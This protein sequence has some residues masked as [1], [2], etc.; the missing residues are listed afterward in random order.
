MSARFAAQALGLSIGLLVYLP[1][2]LDAANLSKVATRGKIILQEKM[3]IVPR[4]RTRWRESVRSA[5]RS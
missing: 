3:R 2:N 1:A 4:H 5:R